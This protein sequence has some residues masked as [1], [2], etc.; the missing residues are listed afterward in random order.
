VP[1]LPAAR[2]DVSGVV[3]VGEAHR[4]TADLQAQWLRASRRL[5]PR[6]LAAERSEVEVRVAVVELLD[7]PVVVE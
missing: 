2:L 1:T 5:L 7:A 4:G 3:L 6:L